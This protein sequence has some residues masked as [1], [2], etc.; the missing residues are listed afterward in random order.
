MLSSAS[1][2]AKQALEIESC[3][4]LKGPGGLH[5]VVGHGQS[6]LDQV[7]QHD[8]VNVLGAAVD[9]QQ[10]SKLILACEERAWREIGQCAL[11]C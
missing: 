2:K 1:N 11:T 5:L 7:I 3:H 6:A 9:A 8:S 4:Y 10:M